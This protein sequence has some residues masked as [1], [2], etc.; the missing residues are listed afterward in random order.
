MISKD[1]RH[2]PEKELKTICS[3]HGLTYLGL[4]G[5]YARKDNQ[6]GSDV[7]L[8][9]DYPAVKS[10]FELSGIKSDMENLLRKNVDLVLRQNIKPI[11]RPYIERDLI[12]IYE[13]N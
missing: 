9:I 2:L 1:T 13:Q 6:P 7:D 10:F 4:F 3:Q 12:T 8:L 5:S 11:I